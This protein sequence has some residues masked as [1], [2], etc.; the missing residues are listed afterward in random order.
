MALTTILDGLG[1][2]RLIYL[3]GQDPITDRSGTITITDQ[4][5]VLMPANPQRGGFRVQ[6]LSANQNVMTVNEIGSDATILNSW[7][8]YASQSFPPPNYP[9]PVGAVT[10]AGTAGDAFVAREW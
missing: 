4:S 10:I 8:I 3:Q 9:I 6:N 1:F 2:P 7:V 5:Q